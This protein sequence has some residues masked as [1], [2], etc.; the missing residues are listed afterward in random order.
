MIIENSLHALHLSLEDLSYQLVSKNFPAARL[1]S[2][3]AL[4]CEIQNQPYDLLKSSWEIEDQTPPESVTTILGRATRSELSLTLREPG[5]WHLLLKVDFVLFE[6]W[7]FAGV[8]MT[9]TNLGDPPIQ[10]LEITPVLIP[11]GALSF[12][13][14]PAQSPA[15]YSHGWQSW[16]ATGTYGLDE[17]QR[18]SM[19]GPFQQPMVINDS[20]RQT[21]NKNHFTGDFFGVLGDRKLNIGL[22]AGFLS[23]KQAFGS[24][25]SRL[26]PSPSLQLTAQGDRALLMPQKT[27]T[28]DLALVG[29]LDLNQPEPLIPYFQAVAQA[30]AIQPIDTAPSGWC[31]W[32]QFYD[33]VSAENIK[34]NIAAMADI[35]S[36][37]P[38]PL[39]QI[40][41]G[42]E[43]YPGDWFDF[44]ER[45]PDGLQP[46][47]EKIKSQHLTPG[48]WLAPFIVHPKSRLAREHPDW[49]LRD[50]HGKLVNAGFVWNSFN[51][52]L[53]LTHPEA[54]AYTC[55][56]IH[57]AV[58]SWGFT[59]LKL[60][61]LY[62]AAL[63]GVYQDP[64]QTRA[65]VMRRGLEALRD[66]AGPDITMLACG[67]P[68]G[69]ALGLFEA[70]RIGADVS[71][72]W[73]PHFPP[74]SPFLKKEP[75]MPSVRN[76]LQNVISRAPMHRHWWVNDPD[77][78]L[79]RPETK[80]TL[81]EVQTLASAIALTGGSLLL[82]DDLPKLP[83]NRLKILRALLPLI[84]QRAQVLDWFDAHTP[85]RLRLDIEGSLGKWVLLGF[86][87]WSDHAET[88]TFSTRLFDLNQPQRWWFREFWTGAF[89][90]IRQD[91]NVRFE[92]I[93]PHGCRVIALRPCVPEQPSY[94]GSNL[95]LSQGL[96]V[97]T[98]K[99]HPDHYEIQWHPD[100]GHKGRIWLYLPAA[101]KAFAD[102]ADA[103]RM[104]CYAL[105]TSNADPILIPK[106]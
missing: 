17:K 35:Q 62:A 10:L 100:F 48:V 88:W 29:F 36:E 21:H 27:F 95:H 69:S 34:D 3:L 30:H 72:H 49:L 46:L 25:E 90:L 97:K 86:F 22:L 1:H 24:V 7:P 50:Q 79:I 8:Q 41:D 56:V 70:M 85:S 11:A 57:T 93:P 75:H 38:L 103:M 32:Y 37:L 80:L 14:E 59:Y 40:D 63:K 64:T 5:R 77:C 47:V 61:F 102:H 20:A 31:S 60:D 6:T 18:R 16:S 84:D 83:E 39:M 28:T 73:K 15:F 98:F 99:E 23:Q 92:K 82:S 89:G 106:R 45:F 58:Q 44:N 78:L 12:S 53:D 51:Y 66:A 55:E 96:E 26:S 52:A 68:I 2:H 54:L 74:L 94:L 42:F 104:T 13:P 33:R 65:Q 76:A 91:A 101:S 67:C 4:G 9:I 19:L 87:N 71:G 43:T 105:E 81:P